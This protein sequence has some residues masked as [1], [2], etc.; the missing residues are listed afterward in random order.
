MFKN[1]K[2]NRVGFVLGLFYGVLILAGVS[3]VSAATTAYTVQPGDTWEKVAASNSISV[4]QLVDLNQPVAGTK[5]NVPG[6]VVVPPVTP[7]VVPPTAGEIVIK[8]AYTTAYGWPDNTPAGNN[9]DVGGVSGH[10]GGTGTFADPITMA[11]G[12]SLI[13][14]KEVDDYAAGTKFY[15]PNLR[16]YFAIGDTCGD[17]KSPQTE[18]CHVSEVKGTIQLDMWVGGQGLSKSGTRACEDAITRTGTLIENPAS[19]YAVVAGPVYSGSCATQFG[20][21]LVT[22]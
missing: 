12:F 2:F 16:K 22:Q 15:D 19:N 6:A 8:N 14:G 20:D 3:M 11:T 1:I 9:T 13:G 21:T 18:A 4:Q 5:L 10:A 7:P 17:G